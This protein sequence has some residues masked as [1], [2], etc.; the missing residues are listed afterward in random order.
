VT[1]KEVVSFRLSKELFDALNELSRETGIQRSELLRL[2]VEKFLL[3]IPAFRVSR[4]L[5]RGSDEASEPRGS[6]SIPVFRVSR[7]LPYLKI[8]QI[9]KI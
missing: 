6:L 9:Q 2:A 7:F 4:F 3:S 1:V 5:R 8:L